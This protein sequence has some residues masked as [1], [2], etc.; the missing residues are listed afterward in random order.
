MSNLPKGLDYTII[1]T[2]SSGNA[3]LV[4][5]ILFD[6]GISWKMLEPYAT[7]VDV[8]LISHR[9][10][11]HIRPS[12]LNKLKSLFPRVAIIAPKGFYEGTDKVQYEFDAILP[13]NKKLLIKGKYEVLCTPIPHSVP[14]VAFV[15]K[16]QDGKTVMYATDT[17]S[18]DHLHIPDLDLYLLESNYSELSIVKDQ[19]NAV[20]AVTTHLSQEASF[21]WY[22]RNRGDNSEYVPLHVHMDF[23]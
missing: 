14:N 5:G 6:C 16:F 1:K 7:Q 21:G 22:L 12:T 20:V 17:V 19:R 15:V 18:L 8:V 10:Q 3:V 23:K 9:H 2:G 11:D 13:H 4:N